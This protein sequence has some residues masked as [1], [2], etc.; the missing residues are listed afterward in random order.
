MKFIVVVLMALCHLQGITQTE[1]QTEYIAE[2]TC[3]CLTAKKNLNKLSM[4]E[5]QI[6]MGLCMFTAINDAGMDVDMSK[7]KTLE[8][9]GEKIGV[10]LAV[11][12]PKFTETLMLLMK[13]EPDRMQDL[14]EDHYEDDLEQEEFNLECTGVLSAIDKGQFATLK[15][16]STN[17]KSETFYW[18]EYFEGS[19]L[20]LDESTTITGKKVKIDYI[21]KEFFIPK[22]NEY[23]KVK[24]IRKLTLV[25][26]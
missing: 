25:T 4:D 14:I 2:S 15:V 3:K 13:E 26:Y 21:E 8:K 22:Y 23:F 18:L 12:C 7:P 1:E 19:N 9:I 5:I 11:T 20:L 16:L 17:E 10:K 6:E 24:V